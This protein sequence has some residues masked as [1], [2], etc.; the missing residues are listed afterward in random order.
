LVVLR[1]WLH[2]KLLLVVWV[3]GWMLW[4]VWELRWL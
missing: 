4:V 3:W 2:L 1:E